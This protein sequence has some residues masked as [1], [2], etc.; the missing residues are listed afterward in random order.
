MKKRLT[1]EQKFLY[2]RIAILGLALGAG[3]SLVMG[4][5]GFPFWYGAFVL[6]LSL[7]LGLINW[8]EHTFVWLAFNKP[9]IAALFFA[10]LVAT[11]YIGDTFGL[12]IHLWFYP[13]YHGAGL[14]W[15]YFVLYPF[16]GLAVLEL[17]YA[18]GALL[19]ER[20]TFREQPLTRYHHIVDTG[21]DILFLFL[22]LLILLGAV[23]EPVTFSFVVAVT[24]I[25]YAL[26]LLKLRLHLKNPGHY[27]FVLLLG[28]LLSLLLHEI[29]NASAREWVYW[30]GPF[31]GSTFLGLPLFVFL[32]WYALTLVPL[33]LWIYLVRHPDVR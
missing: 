11:A 26:V 5:K 29:P 6:C 32:G 23:G 19:N 4:F 27:T 13:Y 16:G 30:S 12:T 1:K 10:G 17:V 20:L 9:Y 2:S 21:E 3:A 18:L 14:L 24:C 28:T 31:L 7:C 33:R 25:W 8:R 22:S 15:V